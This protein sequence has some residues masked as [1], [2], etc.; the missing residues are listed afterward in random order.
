MVATHKGYMVFVDGENLTLQA[1]ALA[2]KLG[3]DITDENAFPFYKKD[4][5][6]WPR[7][8]VR[9]AWWRQLVHT[10]Q[11][12]QRCYYYTSTSGGEDVVDAVHDALANKEFSPVVIRKK[13][14]EKKTKGV[15]ISLT[16]DM[17]V[18]AYLGNYDVAV[19]VAGDGDYQPVLE[20]LK[21]LGKWVIVSFLE[22]ASGFSDKLRRAADQYDPFNLLGEGASRGIVP[23]SFV[24]PPRP[25]QIYLDM[26]PG[27]KSR[28]TRLAQSRAPQ[29]TLNDE[30]ISALTRH[31][32]SEEAARELP[33][34]SA[35][36]PGDPA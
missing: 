13:A 5:Y 27:L 34:V 22:G 26:S 19:L 1:Q 11:P 9:N 7:L 16:K 36:P 23:R 4:V 3:Y 25:A 2:E 6:F 12:A 30:V 31:A 29:R 15:D 18:Q 20:E 21:R 32:E 24:A 28:L 33:P 17:L 8:P 10:A 14:R 35:P